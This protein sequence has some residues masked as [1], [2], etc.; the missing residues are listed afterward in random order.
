MSLLAA[1][2]EDGLDSSIS[3]AL[4]N[5]R[6]EVFIAIRTDGASGLGT[7]DDPYNGSTHILLDELL[8]SNKITT[9]MTLRFGPGIFQ[10]KGNGGGNFGFAPRSGQRF[11]GAGMYQT[12][13]Q[14]VHA[15]PELEDRAGG[16]GPIGSGVEI[17]DLEI[18]DLTLDANTA[19]QPRDEQGCPARIECRGAGF[20]TGLRIRLKRVRI[21]NWGTLTPMTINGATVPAVNTR[22]CFPIF[23]KTGADTTAAGENIVEDCVLEQP[24]H[25]QARE[26]T[27]IQN[28]SGSPR[29]YSTTRQNYLKR[30]SGDWIRISG[31]RG[32]GSKRVREE[33]SLAT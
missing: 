27:M 8:S 17:S 26:S 28:N 4:N 22:E 3:G 23:I 31:A 20:S 14:L 29:L 6:K 33:R 1:F 30:R 18:M 16:P 9:M 5:V 11:I 2:I 25:S 13:L 19:R 32:T 15:A 21:I 10:T 7:I 24:D 12:T